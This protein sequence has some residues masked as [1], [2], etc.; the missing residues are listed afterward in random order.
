MIIGTGLGVDVSDLTAIAGT[1]TNNLILVFQR[2]FDA[3]KNV[4]WDALRQLCVD[5]PQQL[6]RAK[7]DLEEYLSK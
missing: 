1:A 2:W 3:N 7:A 4:S 5:Y 6:G